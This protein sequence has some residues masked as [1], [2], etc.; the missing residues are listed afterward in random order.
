MFY[1]S[2]L[3]FGALGL[4]ALAASVLF[5]F[6]W[7]GVRRLL[8][9]LVV[10]VLL[11]AAMLFSGIHATLAGVVLAL[12]IP[13]GDANGGSRRGARN[14]DGSPLYRLEDALGFGVAFIVV[15]IFGFANAGVPLHGLTMDM[16]LAPLTLGIML[17]LFIGK[18][19]GIM[20]FVVASLRLGLV[21]MPRGA[22]WRELYGVAILCGIGFTMSL[23][24]GLLAF[25]DAEHIAMTKLAVL[26]GSLTST[27]VGA[28]VLLW[29]K[30][31][32]VRRVN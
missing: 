2:D 23:F 3:S 30:R 14:N 13:L 4:S 25:S 12:M 16:L 8:P 9:Y 32:T 22:T 21:H 15:P 27:I 18:Q 29:P 10:G 26:A 11:W 31:Q 5:A 19:L 24:I 1:A 17:G 20:T 7:F 28:I 6:N